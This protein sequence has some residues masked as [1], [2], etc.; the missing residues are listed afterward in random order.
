MPVY[1]V[2]K[3]IA[4]SVQSVLN[5]THLDFELLIVIDST[6]DKSKAI[7]ETF[8]DERI[9]IF[10][11]ENGGLSDSRNYGLESKWRVCLFY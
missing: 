1:N 11:K 5:Q 8:Q 7:A 9:K 2:E 4:K 10:E 6:L 3:Y